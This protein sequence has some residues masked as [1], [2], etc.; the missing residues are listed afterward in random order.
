MD[1]RPDQQLGPSRVGAQEAEAVLKIP[2]PGAREGVPI[3]RIRV[4]AEAV[5]VGQE[6]EPH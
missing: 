3:Q 6:S 4:E 2:D 5:G 1:G